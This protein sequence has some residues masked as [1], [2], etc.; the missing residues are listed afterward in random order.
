[1]CYEMLSRARA[2]EMFPCA[3]CACARFVGGYENYGSP[4]MFGDAQ[5]VKYIF[6]SN[7]VLGL[8]HPIVQ[9]IGVLHEG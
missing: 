4:C 6:F 7:K 8:K 1:M 2:H 9:A 3:L 5:G